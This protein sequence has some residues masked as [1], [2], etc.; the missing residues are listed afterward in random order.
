M[1]IDKKLQ[2]LK[3]RMNLIQGLVTEA[4]KVARNTKDCEKQHY[5]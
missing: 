2:A 1:Y 4:S 5:L 3:G